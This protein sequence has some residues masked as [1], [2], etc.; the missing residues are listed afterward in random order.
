MTVILSSLFSH[1]L[2]YR[3][4]HL[5][6]K[7]ELFSTL[8]AFLTILAIFSGTP[9]AAEVLS[10]NSSKHNVHLHPCCGCAN[11]TNMMCV[12]SR[13]HKTESKLIC[14]MTVVHTT[15]DAFGMD[16]QMKTESKIMCIPILD[17][18]EQDED[19]HI[20]LPDSM[21]Q[22]HSNALYSGILILDM[23]FGTIPRFENSKLLRADSCVESKKQNRPLLS[24]VQCESTSC[25][26]RQMILVRKVH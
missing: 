12:G 4:F 8:T 15:F 24:L 23:R 14:R 13:M 25:V 11:S 9:D 6:A 18:R 19:F 16:S 17:G 20:L 21:L 5:E 22:E 10:V 2:L 1:S 3:G 7:M 26:F